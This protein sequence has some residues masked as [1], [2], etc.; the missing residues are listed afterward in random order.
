M[1][2]LYTGV[3]KG[4]E[5]PLL[6]PPLFTFDID[7][8]GGLSWC[9]IGRHNGEG[10]EVSHRPDLSHTHPGSSEQGCRN[11]EDTEKDNVP[12]EATTFLAALHYD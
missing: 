5:G 9:V 6:R 10:R 4:K 1:G 11:V 12:V 7:H 8:F 3:Q 2:K